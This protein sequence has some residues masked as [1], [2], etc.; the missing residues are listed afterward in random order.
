M[1]EFHMIARWS[2][3]LLTNDNEVAF[4]DVVALDAD[5][6]RLYSG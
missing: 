6:D 5:L 2:G 3:S 4:R 1:G